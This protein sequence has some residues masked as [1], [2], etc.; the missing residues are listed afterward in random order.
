VKISY[1][2]TTPT[3]ATQQNSPQ[4]LRIKFVEFNNSF[5][6]IIFAIKLYISKVTELRSF[7]LV[8]WKIVVNLHDI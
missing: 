8:C 4:I 3:K 1:S 7:W 5:Q 6:Q 2:V